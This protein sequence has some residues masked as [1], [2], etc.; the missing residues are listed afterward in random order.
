M[1]TNGKSNGAPAVNGRAYPIEGPSYDV[2]VIH[3]DI[4]KVSKMDAHRAHDVRTHAFIS[5]RGSA[6]PAVQIAT[7]ANRIRAALGG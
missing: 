6:L 2:V 1:A 4:S 5:S 7:L 3:P